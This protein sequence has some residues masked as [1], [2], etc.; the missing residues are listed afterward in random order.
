[1]IYPGHKFSAMNSLLGSNDADYPLFHDGENINPLV[2][3]PTGIHVNEHAG[4]AQHLLIF[5]DNDVDYPLM[6]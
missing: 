1:M 5:D 6:F 4:S 2:P 3:T